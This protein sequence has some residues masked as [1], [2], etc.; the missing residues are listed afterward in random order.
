LV[1]TIIG[2]V[3]SQSGSV[4]FRDRDITGLPPHRIVRMGM[5]LVP[6]G[7]R[8]FPSLTVHEN[9]EMGLQHRHDGL[10]SVWDIPRVF[11][12]FPILRE[13]RQ[14]P[15]TTLS[16]GEQQM[17]ACARAL[18]TN[19][20]LL[21]MDEPSEGLAPQ[22]VLELGALIKTMSAAG[23]AILLVEQNMHFA[24]NH[25]DRV[26]IMDRGKIEFEGPPQALRQNREM[27]ERLLSVAPSMPT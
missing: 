10:K 17:L 15:G 26:Y 12:L 14:Q 4:T 7:R 6:Q 27:Q 2:L 24:L 20:D 21:L 11:E 22:K 19:P 3:S 5:A 13:R 1:H 8:I 9:L 23:L 18:L 16:G 25:A